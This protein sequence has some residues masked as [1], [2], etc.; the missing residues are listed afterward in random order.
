MS[1]V[2]LF[3]FIDDLSHLKRGILS[4]D[5]EKEYSAFM[6]NRFLSMNITTILCSNEMNMASHL[7]K[8]MQ[9]DYYLNLIKKQKRYFKYIKHTRQDDIDLIKEYHGCN[10][11]RAKEMIRIFT[12]DDISYMK[13]KINKGGVKNDKQKNR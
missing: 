13:S 11:D 9:Y 5:N 3:D 6:I 4:E 10:Q 1:E 12:D 8:Q 7:P 2:K